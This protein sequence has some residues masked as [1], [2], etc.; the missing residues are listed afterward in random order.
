MPCP[1]NFVK[2]IDVIEN[3][4]ENPYKNVY[5]IQEPP[6]KE[7]W[8]EHDFMGLTLKQ[9]KLIYK[10]YTNHL[11]TLCDEDRVTLEICYHI[12]KENELRE[13]RSKI[14]FMKKPQKNN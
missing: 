7:L 6:P 11:T 4:N 3:Q 12:K 5:F 13:N 10:V 8:L 14:P 2:K 1:G 9:M